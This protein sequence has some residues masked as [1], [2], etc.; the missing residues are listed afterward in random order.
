MPTPTIGW[1]LE[2]LKATVHRNRNSHC[3][4]DS[5]KP[6]S[7]VCRVKKVVGPPKRVMLNVADLHFSQCGGFTC[8]EECNSLRGGPTSEGNESYK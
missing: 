2:P 4:Q 6:E 7:Y 8:E 1:I 5:G 3:W